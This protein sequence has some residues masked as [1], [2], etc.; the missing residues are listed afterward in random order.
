MKRFILAATALTLAAY[1]PYAASAQTS[2]A[3][4]SPNQSV[5]AEVK[6]AL[7]AAGFK[8]VKVDPHTFTV[9]AKDPSGSPVMMLVNPNLFV[10]TSEH[11]EQ[12][13]TQSSSPKTDTAQNSGP[14]QR[15][16]DE[17]LT[18]SLGESSK[19]QTPTLTP[20]QK[21]AVWDSLSSEKTMRANRPKDYAPRVGATVPNGVFVQP[22]PND[23]TDNFP[24]L[25]GYHFAVAQNA[26][27]IV[28]P[29]S[30]RVID[31]FGEQ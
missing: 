15:S 5:Q 26:I 24:A 8:D 3:A 31:V 27:V 7:E 23:I 21:Q 20:G 30:K 16:D 9:Q 19:G 29:K 25:S 28:S 22:L 10:S 1:L 14:V 2:K 6:Q 12:E 18:G 13:P 11:D 17:L 4:K